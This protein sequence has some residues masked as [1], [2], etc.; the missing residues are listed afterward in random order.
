M[1]AFL[2]T[3]VL[4]AAFW[5]DHPQHPSSLALVKA[6]TRATACCA[7]HSIAEVYSVMTRLP[8][9]PPIP[10][11]QALLFI[12]QIR[13]RFTVVTLTERDYFATVERL[14]ASGLARSYIYDGLIM[15]AAAKSGAG[16]IY[17][18]NSDDFKLVSPAETAS[19]IR[20]P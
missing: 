2:D 20:N 9:K 10:A 15:T 7:A 14:A 6:A 18:W 19:R 17:T 11:E 8:V 12:R 16:E 1:K 13:E 4:V 5:G 3:S